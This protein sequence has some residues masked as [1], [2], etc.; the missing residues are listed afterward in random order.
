MAT[1]EWVKKPKYAS[2]RVVQVQI[3]HWA[4]TDP[5]VLRCRSVW[6]SWDE[7]TEIDNGKET[8]EV[9]KCRR[10]GG[11]KYRIVN[12]RTGAVLKKWQTLLDKDYYMPAGQGRI[13]QTG[14]NYVRRAAMETIR[15][16]VNKEEGNIYDL[17]HAAIERNQGA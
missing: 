8:A 3:D 5:T 13:S 10:C 4:E 9:L 1:T 2:A 16:S 6:H 12:S 15:D 14:M 11:F 7:C 17:V